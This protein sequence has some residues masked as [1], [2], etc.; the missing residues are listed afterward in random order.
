LFVVIIITPLAPL[1]PYIAVDEAS[2]NTSIDAISAGATSEMEGTGNPSTI[3]KGVLSPV[4]DPPPRTLIDI[5]ASG[6]P[7]V[8]LICTPGSFPWIASTADAT[9][10]ATIASALI[11][12]TAPVRSFLRAVPYPIATTSSKTLSL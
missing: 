8:A 9:G 6:E 3:N 7:S 10:A 11:E 4:M 2:F 1:E 5:S 12:E